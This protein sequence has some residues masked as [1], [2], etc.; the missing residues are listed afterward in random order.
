VPRNPLDQLTNGRAFLEP[1][2]APAGFSW[3][4]GDAGRGSGGKFASGAYARGDRRL[5]LHF[6]DGLGLVTYHVGRNSVGHEDYMR[7]LGHY[8]E[9][10][11]PGF[12]NDPLDGF[13]ALARDMQRWCS[14]FLSGDGESVSL[15]QAHAAERAKGSGF[16]RLERP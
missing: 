1:V 10:E 6:R 15:A 4:P 11:F 8:R 13:G 16:A 14:D 3:V 12:P 7:H 5:E 9:A 2:L